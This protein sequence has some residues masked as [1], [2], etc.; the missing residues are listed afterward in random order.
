MHYLQEDAPRKEID[1]SPQV[2]DISLR[3]DINLS[4]NFVK[5]C[6]RCGKEGHFK[7]RCRSKSVEKVKGYKGAPL[8]KKRPPKKKEEMCTWILQAH[9]Q[10]MRHGWLTWVHPFI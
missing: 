9:M 6:W 5:V 7:K 1:L 2:G 10:I 3:V 8:Q 4:K